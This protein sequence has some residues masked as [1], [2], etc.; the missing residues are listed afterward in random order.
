MD[1]LSPLSSVVP[2]SCSKFG[3]RYAIQAAEFPTQ[4]SRPNRTSL[5][6]V[7]DSSWIPPYRATIQNDL[8][9]TAFAA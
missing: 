6:R 2:L 3:I 9:A 8:T 5:S 7:V 4:N 1:T